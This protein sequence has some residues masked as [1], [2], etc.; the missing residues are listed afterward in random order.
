MKYTPHPYQEQAIQFAL[1]RPSAGLFLDMGLGKSVI[2]LTVLKHLRDDYL[3]LSKALVVAPKRVAE[4]TWPREV[5]KWDHL[6]DLSLIEIRGTPKQRVAALQ[7]SADIYVISRDNLSWLVDHYE[8]DWPFDVVI[9]DEL[10]SFKS[11][12]SKRFKQLKRVRSYINRVIG[13]TGT[14][15]SN[16]YLDLWSQIYLLDRGKR[17]GRN[18]TAFRREYCETLYRPGYNEYRL[19]PRAYAEID[20][21][22]KDLCLSMKSR[23]YLKLEEPLSITHY[24]RLSAQEWQSYAQ[25]QKEA[26]LEFEDGE[27]AVALSAATVINKLLQ[28]ANG[29]V[30]TEDGEYQELHDKKLDALEE[31]IEETQCEPVL[32]FYSYKSDIDRILKRFPSVR[33]L[34]AEK[35]IEDWNQKKIPILLAHPAS[36]GHGLNLQDG[37]SLII[38]FGLPWS[39]ELYLQAN[40]RLHR[41]GQ[42]EP[43]RIYHILAEGTV[44][45]KVMKA[46]EKKELRQD[47]LL[48]SLKG[49]R[50]NDED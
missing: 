4:D 19:L 49:D 9:L 28:I 27:A 43:V 38:W 45:E 31:L 6:R 23:D 42:K 14:P 15:A 33:I 22:L 29:A 36:A 35:D 37:G 41:Q 18:I 50:R 47:A 16:G 46:L 5:R 12:Q 8:T 26:L 3:E 11:H 25:M 7:E 24:V 10:S 30:Y 34:E 44:D 13:L 1:E 21:K 39:L 32:V 2:S 40:A 17:L 48:D 20:D